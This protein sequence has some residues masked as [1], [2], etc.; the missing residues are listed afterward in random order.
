MAREDKMCKH[1]HLPLQSGSDAILQKMN[2]KYDVKRYLHIVNYARSLM[3]EI[4]FTTDI[5]VGF[6]GETEKDFGDTL[7]VVR[8]VRFASAFMFKYSIRTGTPAAKYSD[9]LNKKIKA[10]R[11]SELIST[12]A[13]IKKE[14]YES[15]IGKMEEILV[16]GESQTPGT[17]TGK[18]SSAITVNYMGVKDDI[19][20]IAK[21]KITE[22][23]TNT[24]YAEKIKEN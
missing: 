8:R 6:P 23:K 10:E 5:I 14:I 12:E 7:E 20:K 9:Q 16:E 19:G 2:R 13:G 17:Y 1:I 4:E 11:L 18:T 15:Y 3:P 21:V 24:L 22:A